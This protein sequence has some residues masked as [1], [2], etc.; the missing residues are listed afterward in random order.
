MNRRNFFR[1]L[2]ATLA[3]VG[4]A[5][6]LPPRLPTTPLVGGPPGA[7]AGSLAT[8]TAGGIWLARLSLRARGPTHL[9]LAAGSDD[10]GWSELIPAP[11]TES[12]GERSER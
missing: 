6:M 7:L 4:V 9:G 3:T 12:Q 5:P 10:L 2:G 8:L 11:D 1:C